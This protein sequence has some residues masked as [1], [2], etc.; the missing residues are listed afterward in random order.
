M[1]SCR[2][3]SGMGDRALGGPKR[4]EEAKRLNQLNELDRFSSAGLTAHR[5]PGTLPALA[6]TFPWTDFAWQK[7]NSY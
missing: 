1:P 7:S 4:A 5:K 6:H 3:V 2:T